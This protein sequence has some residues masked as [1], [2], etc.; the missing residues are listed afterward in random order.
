MPHR[1]SDYIRSNILGLVAIY[2]ALGGI[3]MASHGEPDSIDSADIING[4]VKTA[5]IA[6]ANVRAADIAKDTGPNALT[7]ENIAADAVTGA[8]V[9]ESTL[10]GVPVSGAAGGD[11][12]GSYPDPSIA[13]GAVGGGEIA[14]DTV[15]G[16][17]VDESTLSGVPVS[18]T[19][20]GDLTGSYPD[21]TIASG[22]VGSGDVADGTL[23]QAD[24]ASDSVATSEVALNSLTG[25][26]VA[27]T[28]SLSG[29]EILESGLTVGGDL[30]GNVANAQ[31]AA[32]AV[33]T[34]EV[35]ADS[36]GAADLATGSVGTAEVATN[37]LSG[38]DISDTSSLGSPEI[39]EAG[40][41]TVPQASLAADA[42]KVAGLSVSELAV[43]HGSGP[44]SGQDECVGQIATAYE[45]CADVVVDFPHTGPALII[46][47]GGWETKDSDGGT[48]QCQLQYDQVN[49]ESILIGEFG[50]IHSADDTQDPVTLQMITPSL[51]AGS[52]FFEFNCRATNNASDIDDQYIS[53]VQLTGTG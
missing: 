13:A 18:G 1:I 8:D 32:D 31:I 10:S 38:V 17:D 33:G 11:L 42:S 9:D 14:D 34:A 36:L 2:L 25:L 39:N 41:S 4:Q 49:G 24:L 44:D 15:T 40:L 7:G 12:S 29:S 37:S 51:T 22:A 52:H 6:N 50:A 16:A 21:P 3:G 48:A 5:D 46:A 27:D 30:T 53:A 19:A 45:T 35:A 20:G 43:G 26:D 23:T 28:S 47:T